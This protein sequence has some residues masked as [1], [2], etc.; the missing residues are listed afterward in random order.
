[1]SWLRPMLAFDTFGSELREEGV[2]AVT[3]RGFLVAPAA[4][5]EVLGRQGALQQVLRHAEQPSE[6]LPLGPM[7]VHAAVLLLEERGDV[8]ARP[9]LRVRRPPRRPR[10]VFPL[11]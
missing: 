7:A 9:D 10:V 2:F 4:Q 5:H 1:S 6:V 3:A 11:S 8:H